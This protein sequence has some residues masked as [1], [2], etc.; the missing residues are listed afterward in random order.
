MPIE[1]F[2][3][4]AA[5]A[6]NGVL[7]YEQSGLPDGLV[8][9]ADGSGACAG[10]VPRRVCGTPTATTTP[11]AV[12]ITVSDSDSNERSRPTRTR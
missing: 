3:V 11:V 8:F 2:E 6:G 1:P 5:T 12:T 7:T 4:P 10:N 9:D